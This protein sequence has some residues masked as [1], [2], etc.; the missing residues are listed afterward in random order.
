[1]QAWLLHIIYGAFMGDASQYKDAKKMLRT[2]VDV[3]MAFSIRY[4]VLPSAAI[5]RLGLTPCRLPK[6]LVYFDRPWLLLLSSPGSGLMMRH[7]VRAI[8]AHSTICGCCMSTRSLLS[9]PCTHSC[10]W[11][12][13]SPPRATPAC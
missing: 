7:W 11:T 1:M 3:R 12:S 2:G 4:C 13:T 8:A 6:T 10:S 5:S 9:C